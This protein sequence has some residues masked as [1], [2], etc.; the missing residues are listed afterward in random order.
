MYE[1]FI[2]KLFFVTL[3]LFLVYIY[4][5]LDQVLDAF[6]DIDRHPL[7]LQPIHVH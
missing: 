5:R 6:L 4:F 7:S 3:Y 2:Y 1:Y